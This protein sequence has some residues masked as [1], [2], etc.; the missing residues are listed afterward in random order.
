MRLLEEVVLG[1]DEFEAIRLK[2]SV[3]LGQEECAARMDLAQSTF[4]RILTN[5]RV[6]LATALVEGKA[7]RIGG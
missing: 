3:G 5:A 4:Q 1:L 6:K 7:I 2:D